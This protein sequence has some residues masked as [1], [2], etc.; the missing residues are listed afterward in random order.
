MSALPP[1]LI[2]CCGVSGTGK[3]TLARHLADELGPVF[4]EADDFHSP[5]NKAHMA[6]GK[7]LTDAMREPWIQALCQ[8][9]AA[10]FA[11]G[12]QVVMANSALR[13]SHR[14]RFR[15]LGGATL[16]M[17]LEGPYELIKQRMD[18]RPNHYMQAE[19]LKSQFDAQEPPEDEPDFYHLDISKSVPELA[20]EAEHRARTFLRELR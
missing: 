4:V 14:Q 19:L 8:H 2:I 6:A 5:E 12:R 11:A 9:I 16:F 10:H 18:S 7:P 15:Q 3:S 17:Q 1:A 13:R 20:V